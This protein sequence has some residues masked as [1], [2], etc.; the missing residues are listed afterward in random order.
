MQ[1]DCRSRI[2]SGVNKLNYNG[3]NKRQGIL[4]YRTPRNIIKKII[5]SGK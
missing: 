1:N 3:V 5:W 2:M 4:T